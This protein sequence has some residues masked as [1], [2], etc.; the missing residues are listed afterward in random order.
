MHYSRHSRKRMQQRGIRK[1]EVEFL[2]NNG[3]AKWAPGGAENIFVPRK[4]LHGLIEYHRNEIKRLERV[5]NIGLVMAGETVVTVKH[6][7]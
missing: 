5:D 2:L 6:C 3:Q 4:E 7:C 1:E